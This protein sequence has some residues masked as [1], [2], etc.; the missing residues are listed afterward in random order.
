MKR[1][2]A[3]GALSADVLWQL[4]RLS[5]LAI[6]PDG[7]RAVCTVTGYGQDDNRGRASLWMLS[8]LGGTPRRLTACGDRDGQAAWSPDGSRIAFVARRSQEGEE[9]CTPQLYV[10][11]ADG[12]EARRVSRFKPG[13]EAFRWTA[14]GR[15]LVFVT[16]W[17]PQLRGAAAQQRRH[18]Q[19]ADRKSTGYVTAQGLYRHWD[20]NLPQGRVP[21]L[22]LLDLARGGVRDLFEGTAFELPRV[23]PGL[24][25]FDV[26]PD[27]RHLAFVHDPSPR[28]SPAHR[29]CL[30]ELDLRTRRVRSLGEAE[31]W[32]FCG[33][34]YSPDGRRLAVV[35]ARRGEH[36][37]AF[38]ELAVFDR[39]AG[40]SGST[41]R[42]DLDVQESLRW[43]P[44][45]D[46]IFFCAE[47]R[48]RCPV[49]RH[50][51]DTER[52]EMAVPGGTVLSFDH[53]TQDE[54]L[55]TLAD[56]ATHPARAHAHRPG[57]P[58]RR[59]ETFNDRTL[60]RV[61]L[62]RVQELEI[63]G[64][65]GDRV[66]MWLVFPPGFNPRRKH[67][68]F[69]VIHGG[70]YAAFGDSFSWRWN[71]HVLA[72]TGHVVAM[73]NYHGSSGFGW[74]FRHA[75]VGRTGELELQDI[76]AGTD[77]LLQ[78]A[79]VDRRRVHAGGGSYGGF[80]AAWMNGH[81]PAGRYRS[82]VC[83]AGVFDR[84]A[85]WSADSYTLRHQDLGAT[86][87]DDPQRVQSQSPVT[88]AARMVTPTLISHGALD[89]RVPDHNGLAHY[90]TLQARGVAS[91]LLW[92]P[93]ENHWI[94][95]P[96]NSRQWYGEVLLWLESQGRA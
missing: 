53:A 80:L 74:P 78:Q 49:W 71:P 28:K 88:F 41:V 76:E 24:Q 1:A 38:G 47:T 64:A 93:D 75:I 90:N 91:R 95:K 4:E 42:S 3:A 34:R 8:T 46:A 63:T 55:V 18:R 20:R 89:Y 36:H 50:H 73:V 13:V 26:S 11:D 79:W 69:Q 35:A 14:D 15:G 27:G 43:S 17:W 33:P 54:V 60:E 52:T 51:L 62:G 85:T 83:H 23:E 12:G 84:V 96:Q 81:V 44:Q 30:Y 21:R 25:H 58:P 16:W 82:Y 48:G 6:A 37:T 94:L 59:L 67:P 68:V 22:C 9:D 29:G 40:F 70:P 5:G 45:G 66:Q 57:Q 61:R 56:S 31:P 7:T 19:E 32:D 77:W 39:V 92:F 72:S 87:W 10:M 86:Y 2:A 65:Q